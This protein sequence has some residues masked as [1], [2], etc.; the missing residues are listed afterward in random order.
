MKKKVVQ[1]LPCQ[2][3]VQSSFTLL[4]FNSYERRIFLNSKTMSDL[5]LFVDDFC[6]FE[7]EEEEEE[8][9]F[10][11]RVSSSSQISVNS[12]FFKF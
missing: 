10:C 3:S 4:E 5:D 9:K 1:F 8:V 7:L 2:V 6:K 12:N 11:A